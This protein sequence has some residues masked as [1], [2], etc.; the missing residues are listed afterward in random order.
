MIVKLREGEKV[1][2]YIFKL[3]CF[4]NERDFLE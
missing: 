3:F 4:V 1:I 2:E